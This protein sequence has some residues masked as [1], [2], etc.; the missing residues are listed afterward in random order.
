MNELGCKITARIVNNIH[1]FLLGALIIRPKFGAYTY[2]AECNMCNTTKIKG[3]M[4]AFKDVMTEFAQRWH[5]FCSIY[6]QN[7][8]KIIQ[9]R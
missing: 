8:S 2:K 1:K 7:Q 9:M 6:G 5:K 4:T 3:A